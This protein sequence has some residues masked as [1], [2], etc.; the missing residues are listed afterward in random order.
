MFL[1]RF[2]S[3]WFGNASSV[4]SRKPATVR[5][6]RRL[7]IEDLEG[8]DLMAAGPFDSPQFV[9]N[10][11][12]LLAD[13]GVPL[14]SIALMRNNQTYTWDNSDTI[15]DTAVFRL[16][17]VSKSFCAA[18]VMKLVQDRQ[19]NLDDSFLRV[20][21]FVPN[22]IISGFSPQDGVTPVGAALPAALFKITVRQLLGMTSGLP[23]NVPVESVSFPN[24]PALEKLSQTIYTPGSY[25]SL[26]FA[27]KPPYTLG[28]ANVE[29]QMRYFLYQVSREFAI[30]PV[31]YDKADGVAKQA[32]ND[33]I[34]L[35]PG[36]FYVYN[37]TDYALL[38][39][40]AET[41]A[42]RAYGDNYAEYLQEKVLTPMG[43]S[44][45][46]ANP[47]TNAMVGIGHTRE[48]EAYPTEV[49]YHTYPNEGPGISIFPD[50]A[51]TTAPY[52]PTKPNGDPVLLPE[53]YGGAFFLESHFG[54]GG[55]VATPT[56]LVKF[57]DS[58][59]DSLAGQ[60]GGPLSKTSVRQMVAQPSGPAG[61]AINNTGWF[62][63]GFAVFPKQQTYNGG[64]DWFKGGDLPG[65]SSLLYH[66]HD[67]TTWAA[68]F[69]IKVLGD[70]KFAEST[71]ASQFRALIDAA[72]YGPRTVSIVQ[73]SNQMVSVG[74]TFARAL[75]VQVT[76]YFGKAVTGAQV[77][78]TAPVVAPTAT[79]G[80][81]P[82]AV[83]FTNCR[84][85][86]IAP[87]LRAGSTTGTFTV[88]A[89]AMFL[90]PQ[91]P[92]PF[93]YVFGSVTDAAFSLRVR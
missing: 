23:L 51:K 65:N 44:A 16:G 22:Q 47:A 17:S 34:L 86:A 66:Y 36:R 58:L 35:K 45:P 25:A 75:V 92:S 11:T 59:S 43:I 2:A 78:F 60:V 19:L 40:L 10:M 26:T 14:A 91:K 81:F 56:A 41:V 37:D 39:W 89:S 82:T 84:G 80:Q 93:S 33:V 21:G 9:E 42:M 30:N 46:T 29:E 88:T 70:A 53:P 64:I 57:F 90:F 4:P 68:T 24:L 6:R 12:R 52:Y 87:K 27:H 69:N 62:G 54:E 50:P 32:A 74:R 7:E 85:F 72:V 79:F 83:V 28:P 5:P 71:F 48:N 1:S 73:G 8:R 15:D 76:D 31:V 13:N 38:G 20:L 67:G 63:L 61:H 49:F 77:T 18:V 55:L 3:T